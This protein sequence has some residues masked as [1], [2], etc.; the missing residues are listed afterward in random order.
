[1]LMLIQLRVDLA[2][3]GRGK[4]VVSI[5]LNTES[6]VTSITNAAQFGLAIGPRAFL[7]G[8]R[9]NN[10]IGITWKERIEGVVDRTILAHRLT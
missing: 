9:P 4:N 8:G 6:S 2:P 7:V 5:E 3:S 10:R 1:M